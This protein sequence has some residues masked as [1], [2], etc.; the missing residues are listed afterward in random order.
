MVDKSVSIKEATDE[1]LDELL[2]RIRKEADLQR[3]IM[4]M[5]R[6]ASSNQGLSPPND[7]SVT[8]F[9]SGVSLSAPVDTLYHFGV[10]GMRWGVRKDRTKTGRKKR[11]QGS[12]DYQRSRKLKRRS[13]KNLSNKQLEQLNR[14]LELE[15]N[16]KRLNPSTAKKGYKVVQTLVGVGGTAMTAYKL[17]SSPAVKALL[18]K[19]G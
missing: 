14:R 16:Y 7:Y 18:K 3:L 19:K 6:L 12:G 17:A 5:K 9:L 8:D 15:Q 10:K 2:I 4:D 11:S 1:Q 13:L